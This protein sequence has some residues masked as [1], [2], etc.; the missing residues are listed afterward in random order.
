MGS[1][2]PASSAASSPP[3]SSAVLR[4]PLYAGLVRSAGELIDAQHE[5]IVTREQWE[6]AQAMSRRADQLATFRG[7]LLSGLL[8]CSSCGYRMRSDRIKGRRVY[9]CVASRRS[10]VTCPRAVSVEAAGAEQLVEQQFL[11]LLRKERRRMPHG[12]RLRRTSRQHTR[13]V[14]AHRLR[15]R[16]D[17]LTRALDTLSDQRFVKGSLEA[18]EYRRQF[19]RYAT[20][21]ADAIREAEE[22]ETLAKQARPVD[23]DLIDHWPNYDLDT[24]RRV[25]RIAVARILVRPGSSGGAHDRGI[26][27]ARLTVEW[28]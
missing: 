24:R 28:Q 1:A 4:N 22:L 14:K 21:R 9:R 17:E 8:V 27:P 18:V 2:P 23:V 12:G 7:A 20:E 10:S 13:L 15:A 5:G 26:D 16:A 6:A 3:P 11:R 25:L 19:D